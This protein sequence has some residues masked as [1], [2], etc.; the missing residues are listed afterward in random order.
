MDD[1]T[2]RTILGGAGLLTIGLACLATHSAEPLWFLVLV[3]LLFL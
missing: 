3:C 2:R 1:H